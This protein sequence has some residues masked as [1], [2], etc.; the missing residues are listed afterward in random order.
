MRL[1]LFRQIM[2][3]MFL[4][5]KHAVKLL[6]MMMIMLSTFKSHTIQ[7]IMEWKLPFHGS[8]E[9]IAS[10]MK[11][12]KDSLNFMARYITNK[13][14]NPKT[15]NNLKNFDGISDVVW[16]FISLVY[17]SGWDSLYTDNKLKTLREKISSKFSPRI[18]PS[19]TQKS[20]KL[21]PKPTPASINKVPLLLPLPAKTAKEVNV[22][23]K[24]FQNKK[25]SKPINPRKI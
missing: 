5:T 17:Q 22:I 8:I 14:V 1:P 6:A 19:L 25:S 11:S 13:K 16:N 20:N 3:A 9:Q 2:V 12:I 15:A 10:D 21:V 7:M 24:Y 23:L 18:V 4:L